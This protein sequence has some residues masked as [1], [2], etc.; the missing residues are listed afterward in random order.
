MGPNEP[1]SI[2]F[3][4]I[5][6]STHLLRGENTKKNKSREPHASNITVV[7]KLVL[8]GFFFFSTPIAVSPPTLSDHATTFCFYQRCKHIILA[9]I[10]LFFFRSVI[11]CLDVQ[12]SIEGLSHTDLTNFL[13]SFFTV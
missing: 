11:L 7:N 9:L 12:E 3:D 6:K 4:L 5:I 10:F 2:S 1:L 13:A 8:S